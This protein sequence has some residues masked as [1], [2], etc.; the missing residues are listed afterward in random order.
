M[1]LAW[2]ATHNRYDGAVGMSAARPVQSVHWQPFGRPLSALL[3][4]HPACVQLGYRVVV[5]I[6]CCM[7]PEG[8][9]QQ[10]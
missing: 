4:A 2:R 3:S 7:R 9:W 6:P 8:A 1:S 10:P 5:I